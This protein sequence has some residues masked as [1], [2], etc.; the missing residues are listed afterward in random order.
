MNLVIGLFFGLSVGGGFWYWG[1]IPIETVY[2]FCLTVMGSIWLGISFAPDQRSRVQLQELAAAGITFGIIAIALMR[3]P[4]WLCVGFA[5]QILWSALH[6]EGRIGATVQ[7]LY[8]GFAASANLG[9]LLVFC[10]AW[11]FA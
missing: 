5:F 3:T 8:P 9:L 4:L 11:L 1:A 2:V 10:A 7:D 6:R